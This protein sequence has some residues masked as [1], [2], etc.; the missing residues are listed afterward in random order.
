M[1]TLIDFY[2]PCSPR[3]IFGMQTIHRSPVYFSVDRNVLE[4]DLP[5]DKPLISWYPALGWEGP[6]LRRTTRIPGTIPWLDSK[7]L[8]I[9]LAAKK[10]CKR[11]LPWLDACW[12]HIGPLWNCPPV[13]TRW[14][15]FENISPLERMEYEWRVCRRIDVYEPFDDICLIHQTGRRWLRL[16]R[17][18]N[19]SLGWQSFAHRVSSSY[20]GSILL[21]KTSGWDAR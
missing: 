6:W 15:A 20:L 4:S 3:P 8:Y 17:A 21:E 18:Y 7:D 2:D 10:G 1:R 11:Y 14:W 12:M 13:I 9:W 19:I 16:S 5:R